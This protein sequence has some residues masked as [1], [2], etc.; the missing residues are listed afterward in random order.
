MA[1]FINYRRQDSDGDTRAIYNRL[2]EETDERYL[3]LDVEAI[4][5]GEKWRVRIDDTLTKVRAVLVVIGPRWLELLNERTNVGTFDSVRT[6]IAASLNKPEVQV[7]PV[8]VHG[9]S[10]PAASQLP[11]DIRGLTDLNAIEVRGS[12]WKVDVDRL[13]KALRRAGALPTSRRQWMIRAA[14]A[15]VPLAVVTT[16]FLL[17]SVVPDLPKDMS[18]VYARAFV[19]GI[20]L[21]FK[22]RKVGPHDGTRGVDVV[23][24]QR[25]VAGSYMFAGQSVEVDFVVVEPYVLVCRAGGSFNTKPGDDGFQFE[26]YDGAPSPSMKQGSCSWLTG[27]MKPTEANFLKPLGFT[28]EVPERFHKAPGQLLA[29][30]AK[31]QYDADGKSPRLVALSVWDIMRKNDDGALTLKPT[32]YICSDRL[33]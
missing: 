23:D 22:S 6:E 26:K 25:P 16:Y 18:Y 30:C 4:G 33:P 7:I 2:A 27:P 13:V 24:G 5:V 31:S 21:E 8:L 3:F 11:E 17:R 28:D 9:A 29:F 20:G 14:V 15:V 12:A 1:V 19:Q 10:L 32:D